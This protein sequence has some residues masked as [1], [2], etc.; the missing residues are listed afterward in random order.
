MALIT[1][2]DNLSQGAST[3]VSDLRFSG[4][5][6]INVNLDS[7]GNN[8]PAVADDDFIEVR[9]AI[10]TVNN[11]LYRV[12]DASPATNQI[13]VEKVS[14]SNPTNSAVD[15]TAAA[16]LGNTTTKKNVMFDTAARE[17]YLLEQNGLDAD[18]VTFQAWYSFS[19]EE[20]KDDDFLNKF[21]FWV[22]AIDADAGKY[23]VG[24]DGA[25]NNG[26]T[27]RDNGT[28]GI[29]TRKLFRSAGWSELD[30][31]GNTTAIEAGI[32]SLGDFE[33]AS[34]DLAYY[35]FGTDTTVDDSVD[36]DFA[37]PVNEAVRCFE[38]IGNPDTCT[39]V[40]GGGGDD[41][42]T[43]ATGSFITDGFKVGGAVTIRN[44]NTS[45]NDGTYTLTAVAATT[46]TVATGSWTTG[47]ADTQAVLAV[48]NRQA[49]SLRLRVRDADPNGKTF[50]QANLA[51]AGETTLGNR[52]FSFPLGNA[53]DLKISETDA[54]IDSQT[55]YT[56]MTITYH[57]TPQSKS[58]LVGGSFNYGVVI[59]A[60]GGT[61]I[62]VYEWT[63]RQLRKTTDIDNDADTN[64]GRTLGDL[65]IFEGDVLVAGSQQSVNPDGGGTGVFI[66]NIAA[67]D[68]NNLRLV[69]NTGTRRQFPETVA[70]TLDFNDALINDTVAEYRLEFDRTIRT[71]VSDLVITAGTGSAGTITSA[72][73][74]LPN[75][76][77]LSV[78]DYIRVAGLTGGD[79]A[80]NGVYQIT[81]ETTPGD[82]WAV[83]RYDGATITTTSSAAASV[84]QNPI[85]SPDAIVVQDN[86][87]VD[88][89]GLAS[90][91]INV[92]FD[93]DGNTQGGRVVST[94]T[95]VVLR[96]I[97]LDGAQFVQSTVQTISSGT[98]L[99][100]VAT[101]SIE[102]NY[103]NA[104]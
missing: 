35:Q 8:L 26:W 89:S 32:V 1:D 9:D 44:A 31:N 7:A 73:S 45:G 58:G 2:P 92:N 29:R 46:L 49:F 90:S 64:I 27:F 68:N 81:T 104:A 103:L 48:D 30:A 100:I 38:E 101:A 16:I 37:G 60:N 47:E 75:N 24:T 11:G 19:K 63:Q 23:L 53:T 94:D 72:G 10:D 93:F 96:A 25:N 59:D 51:S 55:P 18:G 84:D 85:D 98:P 62:E 77:E 69:D 36:F 67:T 41:T 66:E 20:Y 87:P 82:S 56:G 61:A 28:F 42:L 22:F 6:G 78:N 39:F 88:I 12:N 57:S 76:A 43:R 54:N 5:S 13:V 34:N 74:N 97:G 17:I 40:D 71:S 4:A 80:M 15:N 79:A 3:A 102:R 91:D 65:L 52:K 33:D 14:G 50:A 95:F 86:T 21:P 83:E 70:I 99:T